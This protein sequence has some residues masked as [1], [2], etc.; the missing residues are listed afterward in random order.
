MS[1][2]IDTGSGYG[3]A[4]TTS[5]DVL[6]TVVTGS[7]NLVKLKVWTPTYSGENE[8][9]GVE[10]DGHLLIDGAGTHGFNGFHLDFNPSAGQVY[11]SGTLTGSIHSETHLLV[12]LTEALAPAHGLA[13]VLGLS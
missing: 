13:Q 3:S 10:I 2:R 11:S 1:F 5:S 7:G 6:E 8:L 4:T 9:A 12:L